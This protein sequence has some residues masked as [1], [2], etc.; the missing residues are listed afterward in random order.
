MTRTDDDSWDLAS[1]VG[2]TATMVAAGRAMATKAENPLINDPY[3]DPLVRAVGLDF[4]VKM[5]DDELD[6]SLFPD[7]SPDRTQ[8]IINGMAVRT[9]YFDDYLL[10]AVGAGVRQVVILASGLDSRAYRLPWTDGTTVYEIDQ[11]QVIEFKTRTLAD[12][13]AQPTATR[14]TVSI[15]LRADWP[16]A[17]Q[18][19]GL[20]TGKPTAWLAEGLLIYLPS[21]A[22]DRLFD[23][24]TA[25]SVPGSAIATEYVP[26]MK[27]LD[28]EQARERTA[29]F[30]QHGL[31]LDMTSLVYAGERSHVIDYLRGKGWGATGTPRADLFAANGLPLPG[32][33]NDD[34][35]GEIIY[36]SGTLGR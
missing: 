22:Q 1:S 6:L 3:A 4:F 16:A 15:D 5:I 12:L 21:D 17:L 29:L 7:T 23:N 35:L 19:A 32:P 10:D 14:R 11:P 34:P 36:V 27:D 31:D 13:G 28:L 26:G 9:K 33:E 8:A 18:A 20:D 25:L 2:A 30:R 24:I